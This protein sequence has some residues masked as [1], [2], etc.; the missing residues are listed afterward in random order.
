MQCSIHIEVPTNWASVKG[1][2]MNI[3]KFLWYDVKECVQIVAEDILME[4]EQPV[5]NDKKGMP[6]CSTK[7]MT[8]RDQQP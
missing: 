5:S 3:V 2:K 4:N 1:R 7:R 6:K 8:E